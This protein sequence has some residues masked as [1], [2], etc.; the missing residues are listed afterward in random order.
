MQESRSITRKSA[1]NLA[2][3]FIL[4]PRAKRDGMAGLYA[5][6]RAVDDIADDETVPAEERRQALA[7]WRE[8]VRLAC[9]GGTPRLPTN[10]ELQ[11]VI[12]QYQLP[13]L[14]FDELI[15]GVE[16]DLEIN[17]YATYDALDLYCYRVASVV[18][19]LSIEIFGYTDPRCREYAVALGKALQLTNILRDVGSDATRGR[20]YL[21]IEELRRHQV[22]ESEILEARHSARFVE[23]AKNVCLR[24]KAFYRQAHQTLPEADRRSMAT[25]ELMG[26]VYWRLLEKLEEG[27]FDV[28]GAKPASLPKAQKLALIVRAWWRLA[29]GATAANYGR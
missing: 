9:A 28:L 19:L 17:R 15:K 18:G 27:N 22:S 2:L 12:R 25:A 16:M 26:S 7:D 20:I 4:L 29:R 1:S 8:D 6:C 14:L 10:K 23:L 5:F 24:A 21:P 13:F 11:L 3:A